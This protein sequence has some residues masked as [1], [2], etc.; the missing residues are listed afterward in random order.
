LQIGVVKGVVK[1][2]IT[3]NKGVVVCQRPEVSES[4]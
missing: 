4:T 3:F 2:Y 1:Y